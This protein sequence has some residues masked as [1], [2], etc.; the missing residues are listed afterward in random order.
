MT[1]TP[2]NKEA[3]ES[4]LGSILIDNSV[5]SVVD[6]NPDWFHDSRNRAIANAISD[7]SKRNVAID[8]ITVG[9]QLAAEDKLQ[10]VGGYTRLSELTSSTPTSANAESYAAILDRLSTFR[11]IID[12]GTDIVKMAYAGGDDVSDLIDK[13]ERRVFSISASR[14]KAR[15]V[16]AMDMMGE[17]RQRIDA[18]NINGVRPGIQSG[19]SQIDAIT[20]GW[21]RSDLVILAA[22]PSVG[23]TALATSMA[24]SAALAGK[25]VA[26]FSIEMSAEQVGA[27]ILSSVSGVPLQAI[28]N[29]GLDLTQ[30]A[31]LEAASQRIGRLG[32]YVDDSPSGAPAEMKS[33]CRKVAVEHGVDMIIVDYLQ[34]MTADKSSKDQNRVNEVADISRG[35]KAIAR[36]LNVPVIALSQLSRMSEYRD[37]GEPRLS[38]LRDSGAIEQDA[39]V[40][41]M[42]WRPDSGAMDAPVQDVKCKIAKHRNGPTGICDLEFIRSTATFRG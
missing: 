29:G 23:K 33:K 28:R 7:L 3:E 22:R 35:L 17:A 8:A 26:I 41:L 16:D 5:L 12:A 25:K 14:R 1:N 4:M 20:G 40:V 30:L 9:E 11:K 37:S 19:I 13:A 6:F 21:Q 27:R 18:I 31:D 2:F 24:V 38:D 39:D 36:E 42:L 15:W 34:L 32:I 10:D